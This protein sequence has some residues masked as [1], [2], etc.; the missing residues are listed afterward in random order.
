MDFSKIHTYILSK[1][2]FMLL[3]SMIMVLYT[4]SQHLVIN[5]IMSSNATTIA[6]E[7]GDYEDWIELYNGTDSVINLT[8]YTLSDNLANP[9]KWIFPNITIGPNEY[10]LIFASGKNRTTGDFLHTNFSISKDGENIILSN[11][12]GIIVDYFGAI[13]I[14]TDKSYG[15]KFDGSVDLV[16]FHQPSPGA[17]N[18]GETFSTLL[19][20]VIFSKHGGFY[21][22]DFF[23]SLSHPDPETVIIYTLDGSEPDINNLDGSTYIYKN[24]YPYSPE[25]S[26]GDFLES[27]YKSNIYL[28]PIEI[29]N[30]TDSPDKLSQI[31]S[32]VRNQYYFPESPIFKG[33]TVRAVAM[34][35]NAYSDLIQTN[36][37][38]IT[39]KGRDKYPLPVISF[40]L[41]EN[42]LFDYYD[43]IY[44]AGVDT[45][46]WREQ[47]PN[48]E[49]NWWNFPANYRRR[50]VDYEYPANFEFFPEESAN[51]AI[52]QIVG[53]RIH[54]GA[55][56]A[57][58]MK[59]LRLY[60]RSRYGNSHLE[61][62]IFPSLNDTFFKRLILRNSGNDY[63][64][65]YIRDAVMQSLISHLNFDTQAYQPSIVF[66]NG[67]FWGIHN[68]RERY[69][70][71]YLNRVYG[72][73]EDEIDLLELNAWV[74][75]GDAFHY[76]YMIDFILTNDISNNAN[77]QHLSG[78][79]DIDNFINYQISQIYI[80]NTD[81]PGGNIDYWRKR[82]SEFMPDAP[83]GHDGRWR[84]LLFDTDYGFGYHGGNDAYK[85]N[86]LE[87]ATTPDGSGWPNPPW[88]TLLLRTLL[89]N[90]QFK[91]KFIEKF[92]YHIIN[93]FDTQRVLNTI[94]SIADKIEPLI[95]CHSH[96]WHKN[97]LTYDK[98]QGYIDVMRN[99]AENRPCY[100][101][102]HLVHFFE[103]S[104]DT[105]C[106]GIC[107][108]ISFY[109]P[110]I[111]DT[112]TFS[113]Y[114]NPTNGIINIEFED[115]TF[116][117]D[118]S[119][120]DM[121]GRLVKSVNI[122]DYIIPKITVNCANFG[123]GNYIAR[124]TSSK[125]VKYKKFVV[126]NN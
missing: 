125:S 102:Y 75:E 13:Y 27:S 93:T 81:W 108:T 10:L 61:H 112:F 122:N 84:W 77:Y 50:G 16:Y 100:M 25:D 26:F 109:T 2:L 97:N 9:D 12:Q 39:P 64:L 68:I 56:R 74:K 31:S 95:D 96:R 107:D 30:R 111:E 119:I 66:I 118:I 48:E 8:G 65:T 116:I 103:I 6:D 60:A 59:S 38:F 45:D 87:F 89:E 33:I 18:Q 62:K 73:N 23:L 36:S 110:E 105:F 24:T 98:W 124:V 32:T 106:A 85:F 117:Q 120:Y 123:T 3:I 35:D 22:E 5:E 58:P 43:G 70:K 1:S 71:H 4:K 53:C 92:E 52:N 78:L 49:M 101:I 114:P 83:L 82:T 79:M 44:T 11:N 47:N 69:D 14:P 104:D 121:T 88:S 46:L 55:N 86:T 41:Q 80:N 34:K 40:S 115:S 67:E 94:D 76:Y 113:L 91:T 63:G 54:G 28:N 20:P 72:V 15:R 57:Q 42:Y 29:T 17:A 51:S 21:A 90:E 99:F 19:S 7:D 37:Y 126:V